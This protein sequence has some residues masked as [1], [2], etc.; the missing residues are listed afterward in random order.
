MQSI[1]RLLA[2]VF[3]LVLSLA[4]TSA[5]GQGGATGAIS[6]VVVD[7]SGGSVA[8]AEVQI[9][10]T[11]T[12]VAARKLPTG[13][14]GSFTATLLSPGTYYALVNKPGF[15]QARVDGIEVRVTETT[16]ITIS[17]KPGAVT[18]LALPAR[19]DGAPPKLGVILSGGN[20]DLSSLPF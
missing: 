6:G 20:V 18:N 2:G 8:G 14:D 7:T 9:I 10:D 19:A 3:A 4:G 1:S 11:R 5:Y 15:A 16:R 13:A 12:E 17:L